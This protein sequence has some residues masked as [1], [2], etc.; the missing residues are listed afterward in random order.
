MNDKENRWARQRVIE[1]IGSTWFT[2]LLQPDG[3]DGGPGLPV[4]LSES[5][6]LPRRNALFVHVNQDCGSFM[7]SLAAYR[8]AELRGVLL[9]V[10]VDL[11]KAKEYYTRLGGERGARRTNSISTGFTALDE[12]TVDR[13]AAHAA[14]QVHATHAVYGF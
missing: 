13:L 2:A 11:A 4:L 7:R 12:Q 14:W 9:D 6:R 3:G 5:K 8:L 10:G 1:E